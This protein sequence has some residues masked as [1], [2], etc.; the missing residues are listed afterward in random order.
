MFSLAEVYKIPYS[1][2]SGCGVENQ[3]KFNKFKGWEKDAK[4]AFCWEVEGQFFSNQA[5]GNKSKKRLKE[6]YTVYTTD[7][8]FRMQHKNFKRCFGDLKYF[9][10]QQTI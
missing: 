1:S 7:F 6:Q 5:W 8:Q 9:F 2:S 4:E 3:V 10:L